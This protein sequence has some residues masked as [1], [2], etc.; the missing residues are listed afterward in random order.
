MISKVGYQAAATG[1]G[2]FDLMSGWIAYQDK[3]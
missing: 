2:R 1:K 3:T